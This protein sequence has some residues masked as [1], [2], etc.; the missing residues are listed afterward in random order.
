M[1]CYSSLSKSGDIFVMGFTKISSI[2]NGS[3]NLTAKAHLAFNVVCVITQ[4]SL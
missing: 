3:I 1:S 4:G 2:N